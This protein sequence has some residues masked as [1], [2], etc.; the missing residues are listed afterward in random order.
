M[1]LN[2]LKKRS[3]TSCGQFPIRVETS[4]FKCVEIWTAA[5]AKSR[6]DRPVTGNKIH[7]E[8][9]T[10]ITGTAIDNDC[11]LIR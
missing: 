8:N 5:H 11:L 6:N 10:S 4:A 3:E 7:G 9:V 2:R 1:T